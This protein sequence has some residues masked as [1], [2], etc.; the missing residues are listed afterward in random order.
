MAEPILLRAEEVAD[1]LAISR[2]WAY[3]LIAR[4]D[5]PC[6]RFG[7]QKRVPLDALRKWAKAREGHEPVAAARG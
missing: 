5:I 4:G 6:V 7:R 2:A 3:R 1:A